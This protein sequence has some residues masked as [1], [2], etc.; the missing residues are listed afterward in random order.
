[1]SQA[2]PT[3]YEPLFRESPFVNLIGPFHQKKTDTTLDIGLRIVEKHCNI[4]K[5]LH[6]GV[7]SAF[8]DFAMGYNIAFSEEPRIS[9]V[10]AN[11]N[12]DYLGRAAVGDWLEARVE[13]VKKG[14]RIIFANCYFYVDDHLV[15]KA[16]GLFHVLNKKIAESV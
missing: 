16:N 4:R 7:L 12:V 2:V 5:D 13:L 3:G 8:A 15:A 11:L 9:A 14:K 6:G 1:M 10:T